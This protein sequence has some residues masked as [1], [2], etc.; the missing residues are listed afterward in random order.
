MRR[1]Q[2]RLVVRQQQDEAQQVQVLEQVQ[3]LVRYPK[4]QSLV[5][6]KQS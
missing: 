1:V 4:Q 2:Q 3:G 5:A 6:K